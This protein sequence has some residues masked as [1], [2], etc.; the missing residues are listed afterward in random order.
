LNDNFVTKITLKLGNVLGLHFPEPENIATW[1][2]QQIMRQVREED[3]CSISSLASSFCLDFTKF[4][5][6]LP[7]PQLQ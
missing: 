6:E 3:L 5:V 1:P 4:R 2:E 7:G